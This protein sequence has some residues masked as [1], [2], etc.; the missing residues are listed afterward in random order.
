MSAMT[1]NQ[2]TEM[3]END[4]RAIDIPFQP[5]NL[6]LRGHNS[7][8]YE[9]PTT[10]DDLSIARLDSHGHF[11]QFVKSPTLDDLHTKCQD[12]KSTVSFGI[13]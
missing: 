9:H 12:I 2:R 4:P 7:T 11:F 10:S 3:A 6:T 1:A 8:K 5:V 13:I